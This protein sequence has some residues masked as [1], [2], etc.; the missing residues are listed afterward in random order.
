MELPFIL[1]SKHHLIAL[2]ISFISLPLLACFFSQFKDHDLLIR[3]CKVLL[4]FSLEIYY[5]FFTHYD[6]HW[7]WKQS[8]PL[9]MCD[10][11]RIFL[12][13]YLIARWSILFDIAY[14]WGI[15]GAIVALSFPDLKQDFPSAEFCI[16]YASHLIILSIITYVITVDRYLPTYKGLITASLIALALIFSIFVINCYLGAPA[17]YWYLMSLPPSVSILKQFI[18]NNLEQIIVMIILGQLSFFLI[19]F[20]TQKCKKYKKVMHETL[21]IPN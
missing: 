20:V 15:G 4:I 11:S 10:F 12:G 7:S 19:Y 8:L 16:Y 5:P 1:F 3:F 17:N 6:L 2:A 9:N 21:F 14:F 13:L 18:H